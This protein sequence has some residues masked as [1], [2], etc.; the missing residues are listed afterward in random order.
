MTPS[1]QIRSRQRFH[2]HGTPVTIPFRFDDLRR[3]RDY[4][5]TPQGDFCRESSR[6]RAVERFEPL[7]HLLKQPAIFA[8][9]PDPPRPS[10]RCG[11][12]SAKQRQL[13]VRTSPVDACPGTRDRILQNGEQGLTSYL[14]SLLTAR[15]WDAIFPG[16]WYRFK[17]GSLLFISARWR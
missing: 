11:P 3:P 4:I 6:G 12:S 16:R 10:R 17:V 2:S 9:Q 5:P 7:F 8:T 1:A 15:D 14:I 13:L